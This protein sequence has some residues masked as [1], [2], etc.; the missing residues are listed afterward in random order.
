MVHRRIHNVPYPEKST[1]TCPIARRDVENTIDWLPHRMGFEVPNDFKCSGQSGCG[2]EIRQGIA[3]YF[4]WEIC[5]HDYH[6]GR[7]ETRRW[8]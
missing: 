1:F 5:P 3:T 6:R 8:R 2:V 4:N 7:L